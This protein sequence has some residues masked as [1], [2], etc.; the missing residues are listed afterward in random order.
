MFGLSCHIC[1]CSEK[2]CLIYRFMLF[3]MYFMYIGWLFTA[4]PRFQTW[5]TPCDIPGVRNGT[6]AVF[7]WVSSVSST[8]DYSTIAP[9]LSFTAPIK[10]IIALTRQHIITSLVQQIAGCRVWKLVYSFFQ[11]SMIIFNVMVT[12]QN[13]RFVTQTEQ[14]V[15]LLDL[16]EMTR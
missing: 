9:F 5:V 11:V 2:G 12:V 3:V 1:S 15:W 10:C 16:W 14:A 4:G 6:G 8:N 13:W 7:L